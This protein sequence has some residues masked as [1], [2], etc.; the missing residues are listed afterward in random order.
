MI[1]RVARKPG[2]SGGSR[3]TESCFIV[4]GMARV[5]RVLRMSD[6]PRT[7]GDGGRELDR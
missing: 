1:L 3:S 6:N 5:E 4:K 7:S 2:R